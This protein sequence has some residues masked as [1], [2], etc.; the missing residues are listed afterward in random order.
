MTTAT[1]SATIKCWCWGSGQIEFGEQCPAGALVLGV[2]PEGKLKEV[3]AG[4]CLMNYDGQYMLPGIGE[5]STPTEACDAAIALSRQIR[6]RL[7][8]PEED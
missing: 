3:I 4:H 7:N 2:G 5:S 6:V 1:E 8:D